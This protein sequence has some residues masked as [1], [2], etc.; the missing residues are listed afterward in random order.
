M[1]EGVGQKIGGKV[2]MSFMYDP[3]PNC[4]SQLKFQD[5]FTYETN[6]CLQNCSDLL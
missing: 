1:G 4:S 5:A 6:F 3:N 2:T